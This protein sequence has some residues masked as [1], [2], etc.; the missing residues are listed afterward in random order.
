MVVRPDGQIVAEVDPSTGVA[1][2]ELDL[3]F[4]FKSRIGSDFENR[5]WGERRPHLYRRLTEET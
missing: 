2:A 4:R 1:T 5:S 3:G